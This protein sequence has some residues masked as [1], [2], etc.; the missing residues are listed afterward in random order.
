MFFKKEQVKKVVVDGGY[1]PDVIHLKQD[2]PAKI[3]FKTGQNI[4]CLNELVFKELDQKYELEK[5]A[6]KV[7]DIPT[8]QAGELNFACGMDMFHGKVVIDE[9]K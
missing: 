2:I 1:K 6:V 4:G 9:A 3:K 5:S 8:D 7:I